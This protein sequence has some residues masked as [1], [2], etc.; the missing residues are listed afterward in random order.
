MRKVQARAAVERCCSWAVVTVY[1]TSA[2]RSCERL[3]ELLRHER[4]WQ[5]GWMHL[6]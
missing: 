4:D 6:C 5:A 1:L 3:F 2:E